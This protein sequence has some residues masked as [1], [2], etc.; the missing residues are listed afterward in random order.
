[1]NNPA[2]QQSSENLMVR[3]LRFLTAPSPDV[4]ELGERR[5]AQLL[6]ALS[7]VLFFSFA[8]AVF[9]TP[10][11]YGVFW[12]F[13]GITLATYII[14]RTHYYWIGAYLFSFG[15]ASVAYINIYNGN[16]NSVDTS[17]ASIV[18]IAL[19]LSSAILSQR[20]FIILGIATIVAT[21]SIRA[22]AAPHLLA[23]PLFSFGRTIGITSSLVGVIYG[24]LVF[25]ESVEKARLSEL[26]DVNSELE[27]IRQNLQQRVDERTLALE[28]ANRQVSRRAGQLQ[29]VTELSESI[30]NIRDLDE[31]F[32]RISYLVSG[33]FGFYH[34]GIFMVDADRV[35]A[36]LQ[37]TN[38]DGGQKMLARGH[39]LKL[40]TGVVGYVAQTGQPRIALDVGDDA[41]FFDNPDLPDTHSEVALPLKSRGETIGV[42]DVQSIEA[43]AFSNDDLQVLN[44][45]A[46]Q[47]SITLE[48]TR[49]LV[50]AR[51]A[52]AQAEA[53]YNEFTRSEWSRAFANAEQSGFRYQ[54]GRIEM[55]DEP[56][57]TPEV[58][59]A[60]ASGAVSMNQGDTSNEKRPAVAVPVTLR[61]EVIG[62]LQVEAGDHSKEWL[63]D[64]VSL[65]QAVAER[66]AFAL[67]NARLF[68][69]AR[70]RA[71]K[72]RLISDATSRISGA[73]NIENILKTTAQE[74]ER[75]LGGS[76]VMIRFQSNK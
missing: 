39:R 4:R 5:R 38:S 22:Y 18:P 46:N 40:G 55:I 23:D 8:W 13:L 21:G 49:L 24:I 66:V 72:E 19:I 26:R 70:R 9:S 69:D 31:L 36:V 73:L 41:V 47:V 61:G 27:E 63:S 58:V 45:L 7:I 59:S 75:V 1:M 2:Y 67:E 54:S 68:Q 12:F 76:E 25:R 3:L 52:L 57:L 28:S 50:E 43:N 71:S 37:A 20:G 17:V 29:A 14:S 10:Q 6:A 64:E 74:L 62:V 11:S 51:G 30:A 33:L 56:L 60:I 65:V 34:V 53:V 32:K 48:N 16:A 15:F 35:N 42:L 44:T